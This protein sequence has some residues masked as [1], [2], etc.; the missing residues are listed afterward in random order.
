MLLIRNCICHFYLL[1][2]TVILHL[3]NAAHV[4]VTSNIFYVHLQRQYFFFNKKQI[5]KENV[6][7]EYARCF[8]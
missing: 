2:F 6:I 7:Y 4:F 5:F 1:I 3:A 8:L